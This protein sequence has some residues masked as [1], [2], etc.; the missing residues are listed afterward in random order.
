M[1]ESTPTFQNSK[2]SVKGSGQDESDVDH[3]SYRLQHAKLLEEEDN[4]QEKHELP[5]QIRENIIYLNKVHL[6]LS[7]E[8]AKLLPLALK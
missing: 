8:T 6:T 5:K 4:F 7:P 2:S 3:I 1:F